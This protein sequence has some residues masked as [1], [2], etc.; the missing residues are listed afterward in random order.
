M[1][2]RGDAGQPRNDKLVGHCQLNQSEGDTVFSSGHCT[3]LLSSWL[4]VANVSRQI[5]W[6]GDGASGV[7]GSLATIRLGVSV[8]ARGT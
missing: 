3:R 7:P 2:R 6:V 8:T 5:V 4:S 1:C